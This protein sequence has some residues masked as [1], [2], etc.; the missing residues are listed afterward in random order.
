LFNDIHTARRV[1]YTPGQGATVAMEK[2]NEA[3]WPHQ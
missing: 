1:K 2:T 3:Q